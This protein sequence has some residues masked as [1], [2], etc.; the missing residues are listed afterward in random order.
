MNK[1]QKAYA[2]AKAKVQ[3]LFEMQEEHEAEFLKGTGYTNEDGE[4]PTRFWM[5]DDEEEFIRLC[6]EFDNH[7]S[8]LTKQLNAAEEALKKAEDAL[9]DF[10]ISLIPAGPRE[11]LNRNRNSYN[12][13]Q[14][15]I[16]LAFRLDTKT[17]K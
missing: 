7:P 2:L 15:M 11:T 6:R 13:R 14:K 16:D 12:I 5:I 10:A 4:I 9:I 1:Q 17:I 8:N 3:T